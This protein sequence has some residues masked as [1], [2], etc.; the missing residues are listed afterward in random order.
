MNAAERKYFRIRVALVGLFF[1]F[2]LAVI[3]GK[4]AHLQIYRGPWLS[5]MAADQYEALVKTSGKRGTIYDRKMSE[6]AVSI[7]V[8]SI[9]AYPRRIKNPA[10]VAASLDKPLKM[11]RRSLKKSLQ[12]KKSFVWIKRQATPREVEQIRKLNIEGIGF[13]PEYNR[14]YPQKTLAAQVIGFTGVDGEGLEGVEHYYNRYLKGTAS[15]RTFLRDA[16]GQR[17]VSDDK[18]APDFSGHNLILTIDQSIQFIAEKTLKDTV[19]EYEASGGIVIVMAPKTG[20]ILAM[21]QYPNFNP[22][23]Y[24]KFKTEHWRNRAI[25][26]AIEPGS[27]LKIFSATAAIDA[28]GLSPNTIFFC[29]NGSYRIGSKI[30]RDIK[31]HGWLSLQQI[32]KYSSN[33]GVIKLSEDVGA[34]RLYKTL[35]QFGFGSKTGFDAPGETSGSL[36]NYR[37]WRRMDTSAIAFGYGVAV[38][39][40][41]LVTAVSAIANKGVLVQPYLVSQ[42]TDQDNQIIDSFASR[43]MRRVISEDSAKTVRNILRTVV[44]EGGTGARAALDGYTV[45][46]K[47]GTAKKLA[48]DGTYSSKDY[49]ASFIGFT[50]SEDPAISALVI[51]DEPRKEYYGGIVAAPAFRRIAQ[52]TLNYLNIHPDSLGDHLAVNQQSEGRI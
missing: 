15:E 23:A 8:T 20:A 47:T 18:E 21:A 16:F 22:N 26:D 41:Q 46:G 10:A 49:I 27:T 33:I 11:S 19:E 45:C 44:S 52:E 36:S 28:V 6:L 40:L 39:P 25:T 12:S 2:F 7:P 48:A 32:I 37:K 14:F 50:P 43:E 42:I 9:A 31:A 35:T 51:I 38:S 3:C 29:E 5:D 4:A 17:I 34:E 24:R 1:G 13:V 30:I